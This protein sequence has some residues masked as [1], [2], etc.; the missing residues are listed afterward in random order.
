MTSLMSLCLIK[1]VKERNRN[2]RHEFVQP[3][4]DAHVKNTDNEVPLK[5]YTVSGK[6]KNKYGLNK[7]IT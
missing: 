3:M 6:H 5:G 7:S 2:G 4:T 1:K